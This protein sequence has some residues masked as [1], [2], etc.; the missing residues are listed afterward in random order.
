MVKIMNV[1]KVDEENILGIFCSNY[2]F[3]PINP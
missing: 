3:V 2:Y 1:F